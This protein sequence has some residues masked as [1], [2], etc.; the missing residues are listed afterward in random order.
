MIPGIGC[1][2]AI[3]VALWWSDGGPA[4]DPSVT[5]TTTEA[6]SSSTTSTTVT[7]TGSSTSTSTTTTTLAPVPPAV[8][9]VEASAGA[10]SGEVTL[11]WDAVPGATGYRI[12]RAGTVAG[13]FV[14]VADVDVTTGAT[15]AEDEVVNLWSA[16][17]SYIPSDGPLEAP[18]PSPSFQYVEGSAAAPRCYQVVAYNLSGSAAP[19]TA[20]CGSPP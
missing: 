1:I 16:A 19:S 12:R 3:A 2:V 4:E 20:V 17:H 5:T 6:P 13:P 14:E 15:T 11:D 7:T 10:G 9:V 8:V 18:D